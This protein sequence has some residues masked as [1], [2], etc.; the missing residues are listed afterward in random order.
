M[1]PS[2]APPANGAC[3]SARL[4]ELSSRAPPP[5][6]SSQRSA[7]RRVADPRAMGNGNSDPG[8]RS[9]AETD[10]ED[11]VRKVEAWRELRG[12]RRERR[13]TAAR[14]IVRESIPNL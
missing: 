5:N 14:E 11:V 7:V 4:S 8:A 3:E 13:R 10:Y 2:M 6:R 9:R 1:K 12:T